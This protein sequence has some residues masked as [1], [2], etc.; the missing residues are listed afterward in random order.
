MDDSVAFKVPENQGE[1]LQLKNDIRKQM[2]EL[3]ELSNTEEEQS[4]Y[5]DIVN[6]TD[7]YFS[8]ILIP[9]YSN[10]GATNDRIVS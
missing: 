8:R 5:Q 6:F 3:K 1:I 2:A 7:Y 4:L 9:T 10:Y